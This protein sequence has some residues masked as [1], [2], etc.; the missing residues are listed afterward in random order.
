VSKKLR[1]LTFDSV[2]YA[3]TAG[4]YVAV[5]K[6]LICLIGKCD[7]IHAADAQHAATK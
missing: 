6:G 7:Q 5:T 1:L 3:S 4:G 2:N